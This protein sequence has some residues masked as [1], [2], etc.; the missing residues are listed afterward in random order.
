M[1]EDNLVYSVNIVK[2]M[3]ADFDLFRA[4]KGRGGGRS[5]CPEESP[6]P[7]PQRVSDSRLQ[8][9]DQDPRGRP[10]MSH[11]SLSGGGK[12]KRPQRG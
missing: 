2:S 9:K 10:H 1:F 12:K 11:E 5:V 6:P 4:V 7:L 8:L 3:R